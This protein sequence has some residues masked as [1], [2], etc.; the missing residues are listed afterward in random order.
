MKT[1]HF[2]PPYA[3]GYVEL[4]EGLRIFSPLKMVADKPF[5]VGMNMELL[6]EELWQEEDKKIIGYRFKPL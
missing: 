4:P 3:V 1:M 6:I 2:E 5:R